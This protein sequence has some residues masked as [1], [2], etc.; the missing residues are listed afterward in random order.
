M[1]RAKQILRNKEMIIGEQQL[2]PLKNKIQTDETSK[3]NFEK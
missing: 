1:K 3:T 2:L